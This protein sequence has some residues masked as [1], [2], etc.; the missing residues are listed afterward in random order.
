MR[1]LIY[2]T[3]GEIEITN[4]IAIL[5]HIN[6]P[7]PWTV[8][9]KLDGENEAREEQLSEEEPGQPAVRRLWE[10]FLTEQPGSWPDFEHA[11]K[12]HR[13][14]DAVKRSAADKKTVTL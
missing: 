5:P 2:G 1:W 10:A 7:V 11:V 3:N 13:V 4:K 9:V 12:I 14:V 6:L 8:R